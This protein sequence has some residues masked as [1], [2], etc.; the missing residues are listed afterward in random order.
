MSSNFEVD[1]LEIDE[2]C[3]GK[4]SNLQSFKT[5]LTKPDTGKLRAVI[6]NKKIN[7]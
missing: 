6:I 4:L 7:K 5:S 1:A 2:V 3:R